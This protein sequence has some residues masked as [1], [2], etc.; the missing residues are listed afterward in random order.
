MILEEKQMD[1]FK[2]PVYYYFAQCIS[3]DLAMGAGIATQFNKRFNTKNTI[4]KIY[5][6]SVSK[7]IYKTWKP[8]SSVEKVRLIR[9]GRVFCLV[10]KAMHYDKPTYTDLSRSLQ[11]LKEEL[12]DRC[13][14]Y[15]AMPRIGCGL[16][17]LEW[18]KVKTIINSIFADSDINILVCYM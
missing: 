3:A 2:V 15:I 11:F 18:N 13:I 1:L 6:D 16:D 9:V 8:S 12:D 5:G 10:T 4:L 17:K 7:Q 14:K